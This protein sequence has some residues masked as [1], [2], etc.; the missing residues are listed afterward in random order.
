MKQEIAH[1]CLKWR[2]LTVRSMKTVRPHPVGFDS[3]RVPTPGNLLSKAKKASEEKY[4]CP[5]LTDFYP[6]KITYNFREP[7]SWLKFSKR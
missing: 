5:F 2:Y 6:K 3:L 7:F 4:N 1:L